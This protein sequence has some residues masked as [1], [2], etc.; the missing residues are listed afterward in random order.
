MTG[1][2]GH[3][4]HKRRTYAFDFARNNLNNQRLNDVFRFCLM[5]VKKF[6]NLAG[7]CNKYVIIL[8]YF[9]CCL[10]AKSEMQRLCKF[11]IENL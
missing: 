6:Y 4:I 1:K 7:K 3:K 5:F 9:I 2:Y 8:L 11:N 10:T